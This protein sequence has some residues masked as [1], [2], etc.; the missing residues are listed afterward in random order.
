[1]EIASIR[2]VC[3]CAL[4]VASTTG[5]MGLPAAIA[6]VAV[7]KSGD[8]AVVTID[9]QPFAT[10]IIKSGHQPITWPIFGPEGQAMTRQ[11]PM[12][13][14]RPG[15]EQD[16]PHHRSLWFNHGLVNGTDFWKEPEAGKPDGQIVHREFAELKS[17]DTATIVTMN[18]W[19]SDGKKVAEDERTIKFGAD[20]HGRW[21]DFA[22]E[23]KAS[24]GDLLLGDTKE[25]TFGV[26]VPGTMDVEAKEGGRILNSRGQTNEAAWGRAAEWVDYHGV[27]EGKPAGV[28]ILDMPDS[29]RHP[30]KWHVRTYGLFAANPLGQSEFPK[31]DDPAQGDKKLAKGESLRFHYRVLFYG[32]EKSAEELGEIYEE[33]AGSEEA[34]GARK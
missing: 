12:G 24:D 14:I 11:Y 27:V 19:T 23:L 2:S 7:K 31:S 21:I 20:E 8:G 26:R 5:G 22:V 33:Y 16:H 34:A 1:M 3:L 32:G 10:Y 15:E 4:L 29:F 30:G 18:D 17:G 6:E 9:G 28:T 13:A 25:G